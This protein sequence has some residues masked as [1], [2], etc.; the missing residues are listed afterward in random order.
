MAK[1]H[2]VQ[3]DGF[4]EQV[5]VE[6]NLEAET[7]KSLVAGNTHQTLLGQIGKKVSGRVV[8]ESDPTALAFTTD[9]DVTMTFADV[10]GLADL[11]IVFPTVEYNSVKAS[12]GAGDTNPVQFEI[13][14]E[15]EIPAEE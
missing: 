12:A 15:A 8:T 10:A 4:D 11:E 6:M 7:I 2:Q 3:M 1:Y 14:F 9:T 13:G 5:T